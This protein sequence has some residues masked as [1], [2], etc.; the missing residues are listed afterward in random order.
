[1]GAFF[2]ATRVGDT[3]EGRERIFEEF[4]KGMLATL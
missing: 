1:M 4:D 2:D 3:V